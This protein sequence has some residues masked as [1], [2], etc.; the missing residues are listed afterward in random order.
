M[1][2]GGPAGVLASSPA[3]PVLTSLTRRYQSCPHAVRGTD[4][5]GTLT[6]HGKVAAVT[7]PLRAER[8]SSGLEVQGSIPVL[9]SRWGIPNP[10]GR[11]T[12]TSI[13]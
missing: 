11:S 6:L 4:A 5:T 1:T 7:F 3:P 2:A 13:G 10:R 8:T 9:F 12:G